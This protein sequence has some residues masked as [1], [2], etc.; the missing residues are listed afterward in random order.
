MN[1]TAQLEVEKYIPKWKASSFMDAH[2]EGNKYFSQ[3]ELLA[4]AYL[5][6][7]RDHV[8]KQGFSKLSSFDG[9]HRSGK[10]VT[11]ALFAHLWDPTF[12]DNF[13]QRI[14]RDHKD[15]IDVMEDVNKKKIH[16][17]VTMVDEAGVSMSSADWYERWLKTITKMVQMFGY[18][19]PIVFFVAP[20]K[21]FVDSRLRKM[22]HNY[23]KVDRYNMKESVITP[24]NLKYN[25]V[26]NKH[27]YKKP[28]I[29]LGNQQITL[30]RLIIGKP[31]PRLLDRYIELENHR[32]DQMFTKFIDEVKKEE[33]RDQKKEVDI[34]KV[35]DHVM[36]NIKLFEA[37]GS[38]PTEPKLDVNLIEFSLKVPHR[39]AKF[40]KLTAERRIE[41]Q[42]KEKAETTEG[43]GKN[44]E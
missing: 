10:S 27:F 9:R 24:Y 1:T 41:A 39:Q 11:A 17:S 38:K 30:K 36:Q 31:P 15:F 4:L 34:E 5:K 29:R 21:D 23:Y 22:F 35:V 20:V 14:V 37:R 19:H 42:L 7:E 26:Y 3:P 32:K 16:G 2:H 6:G 43:K 33:T 8:V 13:E 18:L 25:T 28:I 12:W 40:V 44:V